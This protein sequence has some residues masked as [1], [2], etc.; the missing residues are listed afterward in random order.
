MN[1]N[2]TSPPPTR[3]E[4]LNALLANYKRRELMEMAKLYTT[5]IP[6]TWA[7]PRLADII[8]DGQDGINSIPGAPMCRR[9]RI[10]TPY[11]ERNVDGTFYINNRAEG[12]NRRIRNKVDARGGLSSS[13][14][15]G[16]KYGT[17]TVVTR[18]RKEM[19][20]EYH[21]DV[22][23]DSAGLT[24]QLMNKDPNNI[25]VKT[26]A[27]AFLQMQSVPESITYN[28]TSP[29][30]P[31]YTPDNNSFTSS[32]SPPLPE[33]R[34]HI[35]TAVNQSRIPFSNGSAAQYLPKP[36]LAPWTPILSTRFQHS[37]Q[38]HQVSHQYQNSPQIPF[39][40]LPTPAPNW[41]A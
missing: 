25:G 24:G 23:N 15:F 36:V 39:L 10:N 6:R 19:L 32:M 41:H 38:S 33:H 37:H 21:R 18:I 13:L 29:L 31:P 27:A 9:H 5:S 2:P 12:Y 40:R 14:Q 20:N 30:S 26:L 3:K 4:R 17:T 1:M 28:P 8:V 34:A 7:K 16:T 22:A 11:T 35:T